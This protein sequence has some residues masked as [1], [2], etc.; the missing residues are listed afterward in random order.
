MVLVSRGGWA[1]TLHDVGDELGM[2]FADQ[3][4]IVRYLTLLIVTDGG[5]HVRFESSTRRESLMAFQL[6][7][8]IQRHDDDARWRRSSSFATVW[9]S[10]S[11]SSTIQTA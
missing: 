11:A 10:P 1:G 6:L 8:C 2:F 7:H 4:D 5:L 9:S 3:R